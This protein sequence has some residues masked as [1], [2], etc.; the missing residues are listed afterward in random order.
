MNQYKYA[1]ILDIN[2]KQKINTYISNA[3]TGTHS[4]NLATYD[5]K[6]SKLPYI[7][8]IIHTTVDK[9]KGIL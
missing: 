4:Q 1:K 3:G 6:A 8:E 9:D 7:R 5:L 2:K